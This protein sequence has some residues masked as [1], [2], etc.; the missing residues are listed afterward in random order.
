MIS[1]RLNKDFIIN[2]NASLKEALEKIENNKEKII[3]IIQSNNS[4]VGTLSDGDVRRY[5]LKNPENNISKILCKDIMNKNFKSFDRL[6]NESRLA[7]LF[8]DGINFTSI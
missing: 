5:L 3:F 7:D 6:S 8:S 2:K 1:S 4:L